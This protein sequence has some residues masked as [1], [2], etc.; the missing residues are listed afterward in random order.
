MWIDYIGLPYTEANCWELIRKIYLEVLHI[1]LGPQ[2]SQH[3][4]MHYLEWNQVQKGYEQIYDVLMFKDWEQ[5]RHVGMIIEPGRFI[6]NRPGANSC[7]ES[8]RAS[9]WKDR[10]KAVYRHNQLTYIVA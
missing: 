9:Q 3:N 10:L 7:I 1:E 2:E 4:G 5:H 8:Y 6:H